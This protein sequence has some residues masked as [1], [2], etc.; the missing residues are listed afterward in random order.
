MTVSIPAFF[1]RSAAASLRTVSCIQTT[2]IFSASASFE[3]SLITS[4]TIPPAA[5]LDRNTST[6]SILIPAATISS[7]LAQT[8]SPRISPSTLGFTGSTRNPFPIRYLATKY[9]GLL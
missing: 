7:T 2:L 3:L 4:S 6:M 8:F 1:A 9:D 5:S